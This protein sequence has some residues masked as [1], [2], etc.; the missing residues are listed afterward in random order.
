MR[1][2]SFFLQLH[3]AAPLALFN[4]T[5]IPLRPFKNIISARSLSGDTF[6]NDNAPCFRRFSISD[7]DYEEILYFLGTIS[8]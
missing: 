3:S 8:K 7:F 2:L 6:I 5:A 4:R 1:D